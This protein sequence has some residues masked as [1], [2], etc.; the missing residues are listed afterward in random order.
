MAPIERVLVCGASL[1]A[2]NNNSV[3]RGYVGRGFGEVLG[4]AAVRTSSLEAAEQIA[5]EFSPQ[6]VVVFGSCMPQTS[7]YHGLRNYCARSGAVLSFWLHDD[8]YEFDYHYKILDVAD[9]IFSNDR[10]AATHYQHPH[11]YHVPLAADRDAHFRETGGIKDRDVFFCGVGFPNRQ[12]LLRDCAP[13]LAS[14][15][16]EVLGV[17]WPTD[18][19]F[20]RNER[21]ANS[22]LPDW[23]ARSLV[24][25]NIGRRYNLANERFNLDA[26]TPGPRTFE[27]A[28]AGAVQCMFVEGLEILD[29]FDPDNGEILLF[30]SPEELRRQVDALRDD[31]ELAIRY[32]QAAQRRALADHTYRNRAELILNTVRSV[33]RA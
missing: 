18:I 1:D 29:Y 12:Q 15:K 9:I 30:D 19:A 4:D 21:I 2:V 6:L 26:S 24:T 10:W 7:I 11:T 32:S 5:A 31:P 22:A 23:S 25:L 27:A 20:A 14:L 33:T 8:P 13:R 16:V 3:L 28:M 17:G